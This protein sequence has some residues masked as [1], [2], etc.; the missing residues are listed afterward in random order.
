M[1][2]NIFTIFREDQKFIYY[3]CD[4]NLRTQFIHPLYT[5][6]EI[7]YMKNVIHR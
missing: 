3:K 7:N 4:D 1:P 5:L 6:Y 2:T